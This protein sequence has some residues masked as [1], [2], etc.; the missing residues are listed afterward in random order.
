MSECSHCSNGATCTPLGRD[1]DSYHCKCPTGWRGKHCEEDI[2]E[3]ETEIAVCPA[4]STCHNLPGSYRCK[5]PTNQIPSANSC[6]T[7]VSCQDR[8]CQNNGI[9]YTVP[10]RHRRYKCE[11]NLGFSGTLR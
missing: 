8:P 2:N 6:L 1:S 4:G 5:C 11:C 3:C 10:G 9:C 7:P